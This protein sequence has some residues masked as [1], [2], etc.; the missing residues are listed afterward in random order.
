MMEKM[1]KPAKMLVLI[2]LTD[3]ITESL[4]QQPPCYGPSVGRSPLRQT[5]QFF[6]NSR[7]IRRIQQQQQNSKKSTLDQGLNPNR[8]LS[9]QPL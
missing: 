3:T 6:H 5:I 1:T 4:K 9:C 8:L 2:L 7:L